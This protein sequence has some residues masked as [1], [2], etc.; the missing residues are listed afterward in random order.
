MTQLP[1]KD[2]Y[3]LQD[4]M[5]YCPEA[6]SDGVPCPSLGRKCE[7]CERAI[8]VR[9]KAAREADPAPPADPSTA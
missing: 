9:N 2:L 8:A 3:P 6:Q 7:T 1:S 5:D 4:L